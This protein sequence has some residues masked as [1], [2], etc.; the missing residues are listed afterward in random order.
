M[1]LPTHRP[2]IHPGEIL[3]E[4]F[5][6]PLQLSQAD[7]ARRLHIPLN[8]LNELILGK[9]GMT[10]D[11]ALRLADLFQVPP[12]LWMNLQKAS[13]DSWHAIQA[14]RARGEAT[15]IRPIAKA[16]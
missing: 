1:R 5:L 4:E 12:E 9:R 8:R 7:A 2:P 14:R 15:L 13:W 6:K 10:S 11:T 3:R 16:S